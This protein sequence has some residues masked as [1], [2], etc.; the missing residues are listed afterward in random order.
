LILNKKHEPFKEIN[1]GDEVRLI[2]TNSKRVK[3]HIT[4]IDSTSFKKM[5][6]LKLVRFYT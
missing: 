3:G 1:I 4:S 2:L 6:P 5:C